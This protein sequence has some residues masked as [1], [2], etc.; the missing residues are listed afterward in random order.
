MIIDDDFPTNTKVIPN[1]S[2]ITIGACEY[3]PGSASSDKMK[4]S[5][6]KIFEIKSL[7]F[8]RNLQNFLSPFGVEITI[9]SA[10][11]LDVD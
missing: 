8:H 3:R 1:I 10:Q 5:A 7:F 4:I 11:E 2:I 6:V 9:C